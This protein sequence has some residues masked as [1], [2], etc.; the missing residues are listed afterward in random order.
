MSQ[1]SYEKHTINTLV[2]HFRNV[3][4]CKLKKKQIKICKVKKLYLSYHYL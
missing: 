3:K 1:T 2:I 4:K